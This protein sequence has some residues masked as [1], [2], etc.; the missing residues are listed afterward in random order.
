[1]IIIAQNWT[2][3]D[4][5]LIGTT[6]F[7]LQIRAYKK[8]G[9]TGARRQL[10]NVFLALGY[11]YLIML[12]DDCEIEG[13][14]GIEYIK[15]IDD[16]PD[17]FLEFRG[18]QLKLFAISRSILLEEDYDPNIN[19]EDGTGFEDRIFVE[20]LRDKY[21]SKRVLFTDTGLEMHSKA[22][23]DELS[24]W[25]AEDQDITVMRDKTRAM[26][27]EHKYRKKEDC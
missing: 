15:Q 11:D 12:D 26:I 27:A 10:R 19:A 21:P 22:T 2:V 8:L 13:K 6:D 7:A 14:S 18:T 24:T 23:K 17:C 1:M 25:C 20:N 16:H 3:Q 4:I 5:Q 9:I